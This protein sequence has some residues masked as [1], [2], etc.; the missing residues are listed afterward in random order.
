MTLDDSSR[1]ASDR[2]ASQ[3]RTSYDVVAAEYADRISNELTG[4][5]LDRALLDEVAARTSGLVCDLGCGPG[6]VADYLRGRGASILGVDLSPGMIEEAR[7]RY[8]DIQFDVADMRCLP[9]DDHTFAAVVAMYSLIHFDDTELR[10]ALA[11][12]HRVLNAEGILLAGFH[13]GREVV[14]AE[15]FFGCRVNLDFRFFEPEEM[16]TAL[17]D[18]GFELERLIERNPYPNVEVETRRFYVIGKIA[19]RA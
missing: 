7:Q 10:L 13:R 14:H 5:P 8:P 17:A 19:E 2:T 3:V 11:E 6:H 1:H 4:K 15:E 9:Y 18:A 12:I 16:I